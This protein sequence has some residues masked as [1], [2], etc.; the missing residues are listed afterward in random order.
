MSNLD[1]LGLAL[2][3]FALM[4]LGF[5][6]GMAFYSKFVKAAKLK[7]LQEGFKCAAD[8]VGYKA[9]SLESSMFFD[10]AQGM[11]D[12]EWELKAKYKQTIEHFSNY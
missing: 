5:L 7:G 4:F 10:E 6:L 12:L 9:D 1:F 3:V 8:L 2:A 11:R